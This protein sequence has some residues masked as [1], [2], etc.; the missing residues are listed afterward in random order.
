MVSEQRRLVEYCRVSTAEQAS[1]FSLEAQHNANEAYARAHNAVIIRTFKEVSSGVTPNRAILRE[2]VDFCIKHADGLIVWRLDRLGRSLNLLLQIVNELHEHNRTLIVVN[3]GLEFS[4]KERDGF[5]ALAGKVL[6]TVLGLLAEMEHAAI[7]ERVVLGKVQ[8]V[9][10]GRWMGGNKPPL[11]YKVVN[12][13]LEIDPETA[14]LIRALF[15]TYLSEPNASTHSLAEKFNLHHSTVRRILRNPVYMGV[16]RWR[17]GGKKFHH[18]HNTLSYLQMDGENVIKVEV[19][20]IIEREVFEAVQEK[21]TM[22]RKKWDNAVQFGWWSGL[23]KCAGCGNSLR[24]HRRTPSS[25]F[26]LYCGV[27]GCKEHATIR[28]DLAEQFFLNYLH[29][30]FLRL[31]DE[32]VKELSGQSVS[33]EL[34]EDELR[35]RR[36]TLIT[37]FAQGEITA[38]ELWCGLRELE[39][40]SLALKA[41]AETEQYLRCLEALTNAENFEKAWQLTPP[42]WQRVLIRK[43]INAIIVKGNQVIKVDGLIPLNEPITLIVRRPITYEEALPTLMNL[44]RQGQLKVR[45]IAKTLR[46]GKQKAGEWRKRFLN[47]VQSSG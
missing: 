7:K 19:P 17:I 12:G 26:Y 36:Q 32:L 8:A 25:P 24:R 5:G 3:E 47:E 10:V 18:H 2:A 39:L 44:W 38:E 40:Q 37:L 33:R 34:S 21:L 20:A 1:G 13:K 4:F 42:E 16:Y 22:Q 30:A 23:F 45:V 15:H 46:I 9:K 29:Q 11:G 28:F 43:T 14:S 41:N 35:N 27:K 6:L 31:K